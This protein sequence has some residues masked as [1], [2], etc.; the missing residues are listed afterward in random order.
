L[1]ANA[2]KFQANTGCFK[3]P[4]RQF[5]RCIPVDSANCADFATGTHRSQTP[6]STRK[7]IS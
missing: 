3:L 7:S 2:E 1:S 5:R 4:G 6:P